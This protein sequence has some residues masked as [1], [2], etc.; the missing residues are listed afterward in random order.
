MAIL[1]VKS[2]CTLNIIARGEPRVL[3]VVA[4]HV[5][6]Y[7]I[8]G[9][10]DNIILSH[11]LWNL[12]CGL[13][14]WFPTRAISLWHVVYPDMALFT[15]L[16]TSYIWPGR[17][18]SFRATAIFTT[19]DLETNLLQSLVDCLFNGQ[20]VCLRKWRLVLRLLFV[21]SRFPPLWIHKVAVF[22]CSLLYNIIIGYDIL[23]WYDIH[24]THTK[25][26]DKLCIFIV[27]L[28]TPQTES[29]VRSI[30]K[31]VSYVPLVLRL[32]GPGTLKAFSIHQYCSTAIFNVL[33]WIYF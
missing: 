19:A 28:N 5:G 23:L 2:P 4:G 16:V 33:P 13:L 9:I 25:F 14:G 6:C 11:P 31:D 20:S 17:W 1:P 27:I 26:L 29:G 7:Q 8:F 10:W 18:P 32:E 24:V 12:I 15:T 3:V 21:V 30:L 22:T